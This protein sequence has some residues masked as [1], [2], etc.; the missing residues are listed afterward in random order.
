MNLDESRYKSLLKSLIEGNIRATT[1]LIGGWSLESDSIYRGSNVWGDP[2]GMYFGSNGF[3][4]GDRFKIASNG[5][6]TAYSGVFY[7]NDPN[8]RLQI[9]D[10]INISDNTVYTDVASEASRLLRITNYEDTDQG[11]KMIRILL[12]GERIR[13]YDEY[14]DK[15]ASI[16]HS[17]GRLFI[18]SPEYV[19][20]ESPLNVAGNVITDGGILSANG[21]TAWDGGVA[22]GA[23]GTTG[24]MA[25]VSPSSSGYP[26][27]MFV[28]NKSTSKYTQLRST[29]TS[30]TYTLTLP[31][32]TGTLATTSS[33]IRLK[34]NIKDS[35]VSGLELIEK[36]KL[37][38]F[39]WRPEGIE[40]APHWKIGMIADELE[41]LDENLAFGGG[42][43]ED[44]SMNIKGIDTLCLLAYLVKAV[45][46]LNEKTKEAAT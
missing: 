22:G 39:D 43:N 10:V 42:M 34:E 19:S 3:S 36:I 44:G 6:F 24:R 45:Q 25:L 26:N 37:H 23:V 16:R 21:C 28:V 33:D 8:V 40:G 12:T 17:A 29:N 15:T 41:D 35:E 9:T 2:D 20:I 14:S 13:F 11:S 46:E 5:T 30:G 1:G 32:S 7:G 31:N 18:S 27:I 4:I 38:S